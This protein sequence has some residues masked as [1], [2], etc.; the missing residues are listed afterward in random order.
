M[1]LPAETNE[2]SPSLSLRRE[3]REVG[4]LLVAWFYRAVNLA[5]DIVNAAVK[6]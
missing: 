2:F 5:L 6:S 4:P 1:F 3:A